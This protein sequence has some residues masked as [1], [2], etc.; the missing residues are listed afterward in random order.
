[1]KLRNT[2]APTLVAIDGLFDETLLRSLE[3]TVEALD[4]MFED[5]ESIED[6]EGEPDGFDGI[7]RNGDI[8]HL[9]ASEWLM[10]SEEPDEFVRRF[11]DRELAYLHRARVHER[12]PPT[13]LVLFDAGPDQLGRPR[14]VHLACLIALARRAHAS[15]VELRWGTLQSPHSSPVRSGKDLLRLVRSRTHV[16]PPEVP[17]LQALVDDCLV[18]ASRP[19][20]ASHQL[21]LIDEDQGIRAVLTDHRR[22]TRRSAH[23]PLPGDR[24]AIRLLRDP[25]GEATGASQRGGDKYRPTSNLVFD[26]QGNKVLARAGDGSQVVVFPAPNSASAQRQKVR[27]VFGMSHLGIVAAAGRIG[28]AVITATVLEDGHTVFIGCR[29]RAKGSAIREGRFS[30]SQA[31][32]VPSNEDPLGEV[33]GIDGRLHIKIVGWLLVQ[34]DDRFK[35]IPDASTFRWGH[36]PYDITATHAGDGYVVRS[37]TTELTVPAAGLRPFGITRSSDAGPALLCVVNDSD[38]YSVTPIASDLICRAEAPV[39]DA[40]AHHE[41]PQFAYRT[42]AGHVAVRNRL[43]GDRCYLW[44]AP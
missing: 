34:H 26:R 38:I 16:V 17:P 39:I 18:V 35:V 36:P 33:Y 12:R 44:Q 28:R 30:L 4:R 15:G 41:H 11:S 37:G 3:L 43:T 13:S 9:L 29:G 42:T 1:M 31:V 7:D 32:P 19:V 25:T 14:L 20:G 24:D 6:P 10:V 40:V 2:A 21:Q 8:E 27:V 23:V 5:G 22:G